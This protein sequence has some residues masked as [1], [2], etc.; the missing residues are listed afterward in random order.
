[1]RYGSTE[2]IKAFLAGKTR[3]I[4]ND[5]T[6]GATLWFHGNR[7]AWREDD[8]VHMTLCGWNT[9]T[10]RLR[11]NALCHLLFGGNAFHQVKHNAMLDGHEVE[12]HDVFTWRPGITS[13]EQMLAFTYLTG[14]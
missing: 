12:A 2:V 10:T 5:H 1:M 13:G 7:I 11:L 14:E 4:K 8:M 9:V 6:D 3:K